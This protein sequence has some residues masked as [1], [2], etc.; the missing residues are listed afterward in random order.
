M[1]TESWS[2]GQERAALKLRAGLVR[3]EIDK[4]MLMFKEEVKFLENQIETLNNIETRMERWDRD[5]EGR[6]LL[7]HQ[8]PSGT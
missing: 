1:Y 8:R 7:L 4:I 3:H 5:D 6:K 2:I